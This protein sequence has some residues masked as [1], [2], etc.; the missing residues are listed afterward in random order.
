[1]QF[2]HEDDQGQMVPYIGG[3]C[4]VRISRDGQVLESVSGSL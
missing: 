2:L 1:V 4:T 3:T